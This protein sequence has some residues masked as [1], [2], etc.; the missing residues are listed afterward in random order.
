MSQLRVSSSRWCRTAPE[1]HQSTPTHWPRLQKTNRSPFFD[2]QTTLQFLQ[3][4][5]ILAFYLGTWDTGCAVP[6]SSSYW[7]DCHRNVPAIGSE[8]V[9]PWWLEERSPPQAVVNRSWTANG[10]KTN[11]GMPSLRKLH[12]GCVTAVYKWI[13]I[14]SS[15]EI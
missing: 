5:N 12:R 9:C 1:Q 2:L 4:Y 6:D 11:C 13:N 10:H 3:H 15:V 7:R 8:V 14:V